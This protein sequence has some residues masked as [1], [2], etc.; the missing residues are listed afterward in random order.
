[1]TTEPTTIERRIWIPAKFLDWNYETYS[2][3]PL[4]PAALDRAYLI[5][6][7]AN[8]RLDA[9]C[10]E[11]DRVDVITTLKR[12]VTQRVGALKKAYGFHQF[13]IRNKP[14]RDL[15]LLHRLG[16]IR[17]VMLRSLIEI[18]NTLE[19]EDAAPP[20][21][22][23]C[24]TLVEFVWYFLKSTDPLLRGR[25]SEVSYLESLSHSGV[26]DTEK[27]YYG[28]VYYRHPD[29]GPPIVRMRLPKLAI[30]DA[31]DERGCLEVLETEMRG[32]VQGSENLTVVE[33]VIVG[34]DDM[35]EHLW[36][37]YF[38]GPPHVWVSSDNVP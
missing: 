17:P 16:L 33:G 5:W 30:R 8:D 2:T 36:L 7:H 27:A 34:P 21:Y 24:R 13:S 18:R 1:M 12:A 9:P 35:V 23:A 4:N 29:E 37:S 31:G 32:D 26:E 28:T 19:H 6:E 25:L 20:D 10:T 11:F 22:E 38:K 3:Q 14:K 15:D